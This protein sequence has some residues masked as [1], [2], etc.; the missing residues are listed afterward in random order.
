MSVRQ[1]VKDGA[2]I[3]GWWL[4]AVILL[5]AT[6]IIIAL[7]W[8]GVAP[9]AADRQREINQNTQQ[10]AE[11]QVRAMRD[12]IT[13]YNEN[14]VEL[15]ELNKDP[16]KNETVIKALKTQQAGIVV[17]VRTQSKTLNPNAVPSDIRSFLQGK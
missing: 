7:I 16:V 17:F 8:S 3:A 6:S 14:E 10:Y 4:F 1:G 5:G 12:Q 11:T 9:W 2:G 15:A 13:Q